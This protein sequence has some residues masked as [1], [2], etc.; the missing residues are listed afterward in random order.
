MTENST[1]DPGVLAQ[2]PVAVIDLA[3]GGMTCASCVARVEKKIGKVAGASALVNLAT[4]S[5]RVEL[6]DD[7][8]VDTIVRAVEAAGYT[9]TTMSG[10]VVAS[11]AG[12][13]RVSDWRDGD[14]AVHNQESDESEADCLA[15]E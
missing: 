15:A 10:Y 3:V 9:A 12:L 7:V 8:D 2:P 5:A 13:V 6:S 4:E 1:P 11:G 14:A